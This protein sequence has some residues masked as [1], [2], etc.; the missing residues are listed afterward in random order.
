MKNT[1]LVIVKIVFL[2]LMI[3][4]FF[5]IAMKPILSDKKVTDHSLKSPPASLADK[6]LKVFLATLCSTSITQAQSRLQQLPPNIQELIYQNTFDRGWP[7]TKT[8]VLA[9]YTNLDTYAL[10]CDG[11]MIAQLFQGSNTITITNL[12]TN[13]QGI[14]H[15]PPDYQQHYFNSKIHFNQQATLL[16]LQNFHDNRLT[17]WDIQSLDNPQLS[18]DAHHVVHS[19]FEPFLFDG[20]FCQGNKYIAGGYGE[21]IKIYN[22]AT[23][24]TT[25]IDLSGIAL[26]KQFD[27]WNLLV[28]AYGSICT[29]LL[30]KKNI[31]N[32]CAIKFLTLEQ[33]ESL[34]TQ[35]LKEDFS[36][37]NLTPLPCAT[38]C[39]LMLSPGGLKFAYTIAEI[40]SGESYILIRDRL[41]NIL[42]KI[43]SKSTHYTFSADGSILAIA[44]KKQLCLWHID[45]KRM[46]AII[47]GLQGI[48]TCTALHNN[49]FMV[50]A[51]DKGTTS[52]I[53]VVPLS[54]QEII[55]N[56]DSLAFFLKNI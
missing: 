40:S 54:F 22:I 7:H 36:L 48:Q 16:A 38:L 3:D 30:H 14:I 46:L 34:P 55:N 9:T 13:K 44:D 15:K 23:K 24:T 32:Y 1:S 51:M 2:S 26:F 12:H 5:I 28:D 17:I 52:L 19:D 6:A 45:Q 56:I 20:A 10:S 53:H 33:I 27:C 29:M 4:N 35:D 42:S 18:L 39:H 25:T 37:N 49:T 41:F 8:A 31:R 47:K 50:Q 43:P 21:H 11:N